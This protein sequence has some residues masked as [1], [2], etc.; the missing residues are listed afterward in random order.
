M[1]RILT[2]SFWTIGG[3]LLG[4]VARI[5]GK[6][7][8]DAAV[9]WINSQLAITFGLRA[10]TASAVAEFLAAWVAPTLA[11]ALIIYCCMR[12]AVTFSGFGSPAAGA[13]GGERSTDHT[14]SDSLFRLTVG[15][16][17]PYFAT[18]GHVYGIRRTYRLKV[19]NSDR[20]TSLCSCTV[21]LRSVS[22][23]TD[24]GEGPW[25]LKSG[26][27][28]AAGDHTFIP[29]VTYG[30]ARD[31]AKYDCSDSFMTVGTESGRPYL[32]AHKPYVLTVRA[33]SPETAFVD[34]SFDVW[35]DAT[36]KLRIAEH[37]AEG[38]ASCSAGAARELLEFDFRPHDN[39]YLELVEAPA[40]GGVREYMV[41]R[42]AAK[43]SSETE[44]LLAV[45]TVLINFRREGDVGYTT[46]DFRLTSYSSGLQTEDVPPRQSVT[47]DLFRISR[48]NGA[49]RLE[50]GP[51]I[52]GRYRSVP[53]GRYLLKITAS[54]TKPEVRH[55]PAFFILDVNERGEVEYGP[56]ADATA[57]IRRTVAC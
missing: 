35:V 49:I 48:E 23:E 51:D 53:L 24:H 54:T 13:D 25:L 39:K 31:P 21:S 12:A 40:G 32:D 14:S 46:L 16:K 20:R 28:L 9:G 10:P 3:L 22:P 36:G 30:E 8:E 57:R 5:P 7:I 26:F 42:V 47:Y 38:A 33:T 37:L 44:T 34:H 45:R 19:E 56:S 50:L 15:E 55:L 18:D 6:L 27:T 41:G 11:G 1:R 2:V 17:E 52:R 43:N 4:Q 29:L